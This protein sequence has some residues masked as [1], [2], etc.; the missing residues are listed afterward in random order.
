MLLG[1]LLRDV[2]LTREELRAMMGGLADSNGPTTGEVAISEWLDAH[3][4]A[5]G[6]EYANELTLHF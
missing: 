1:Y 2:L 4:D 5:L 3:G 6:R